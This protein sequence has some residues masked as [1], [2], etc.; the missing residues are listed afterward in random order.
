METL[1]TQGAQGTDDCCTE[2]RDQARERER[3]RLAVRYGIHSEFVRVPTLARILGLAA[4]TIY[5]AMRDGRFFM[6][7]RLLGSAPAVRLDDLAE[8]LAA[9]QPPAA[10]PARQRLRGERA[11]LATDSGDIAAKVLAEMGVEPRARRRG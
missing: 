2:S 5:E 6:P 8:W 3:E 1:G 10:A 7:H 4:P 9:P 11:P